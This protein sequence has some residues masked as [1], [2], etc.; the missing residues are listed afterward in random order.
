M[1]AILTSRSASSTSRRAPDPR[2][3]HPMMPMLTVW[4]PW[5]NSPLEKAIPPAR[6]AP[7]VR[8]SRRFT[9]S[10]MERLLVCGRSTGLFRLEFLVV[11]LDHLGRDPGQLVRLDRAA[12][13]EPDRVVVRQPPDALRLLRVGR[14]PR[15]VRLPPGGAPQVL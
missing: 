8:K 13:P 14:H 12:H 5:A 9:V 2:P 11:L 1:A 3:P 15:L 10:D 7:V 4:L 6:A